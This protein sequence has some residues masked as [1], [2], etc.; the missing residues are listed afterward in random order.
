MTSLKVFLTVTILAA[1]TAAYGQTAVQLYYDAR[2]N[3]TSKETAKYSRIVN[4]DLL[5][6]RFY[7]QVKDAYMNGKAEMTGYYN[8]NIK[9]GAFNFYYPDGKIKT[10]GFYKNNQRYGV[11]TNYYENGKIRDKII[12]D[13]VFQGVQEYYDTDGKQIMADG[14]GKWEAQYVDSF[15]SDS[16]WVK[17]AYKDKL[18]QGGWYYYSKH[19]GDDPA[20]PPKLECIENFENGMFTGGK[21]IWGGGNV[22]SLG[23]PVMIIMSEIKKFEKTENWHHTWTACI[24][25]Y[26]YLKFLP[27]KDTLRFPVD[28]IARYP[29]GVD[30]LGRDLMASMKFPK[31]YLNSDQAYLAMFTIMIDEQGRMIVTEDPNKTTSMIYPDNELFYKQLLESFRKLPVWQPA[32]RNN[33]NVQDYFMIS[34]EL[35]KKKLNIGLFEQNNPR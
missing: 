12:F 19:P 25:N 26:P 33:Y 5:K 10:E 3:L 2:W 14:N 35:K 23:S 28:S 22:E 6:Y 11:W 7:G 34:F 13:N 1:M 29:G 16:V 18:R 8:A 21:Y 15:S 17:G 27:K 20:A 4:I 24:E 31:S 9:E 32:K 30:A